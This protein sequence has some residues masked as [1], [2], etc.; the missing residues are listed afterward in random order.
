MCHYTNGPLKVDYQEG[1]IQYEVIEIIS[2]SED[3]RRLSAARRAGHI[4]FTRTTV[5]CEAQKAAT[6]IDYAS[7]HH[8]V[9]YRWS[10][11]VA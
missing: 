9:P 11:N 4:R 7:R 5:E 10:G 3:R 6:I 1:I 8:S 2:V